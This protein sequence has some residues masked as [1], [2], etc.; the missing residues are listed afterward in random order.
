MQ[1]HESMFKEQRGGIW[2]QEEA[3]LGRA[4]GQLIRRWGARGSLPLQFL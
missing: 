3:G 1:S 2:K 4:M